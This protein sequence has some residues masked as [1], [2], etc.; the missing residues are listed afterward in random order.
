MYYTPKIE[1][2]I[3]GFEFE[4]Y[5]DRDDNNN[6]WYKDVIKENEDFWKPCVIEDRLYNY[7]GPLLRALL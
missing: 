5:G 7:G 2:F 6:V 3:P 1:E 4:Y